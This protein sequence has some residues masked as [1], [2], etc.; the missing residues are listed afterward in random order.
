MRG[1]KKR[2]RKRKEKIPSHNSQL[3][4]ERRKDGIVEINKRLEVNLE[5]KCTRMYDTEARKGIDGT[6]AT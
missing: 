3:V 5:K 2:E 1:G 6:A 4:E